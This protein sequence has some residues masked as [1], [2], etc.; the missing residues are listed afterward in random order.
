[1]NVL[2]VAPGETAT[3]EGLAYLAE[4]ADVVVGCNLTILLDNGALHD[5]LIVGDWQCLREYHDDHFDGARQRG[6]KFWT[7]SITVTEIYRWVEPLD[8]GMKGPGGLNPFGTPIWHLGSSGHAAIAFAWSILRGRD[9]YEPLRDQ[10]WLYGYTGTAEHFHGPHTGLCEVKGEPP[11]GDWQSN[12]RLI[13]KSALE[14]GLTI[15]DF[16]GDATGIYPKG[17]WLCLP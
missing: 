16:T 2:C 10:I 9:G 14:Y 4:K 8:L 5:H 17:D 13:A 7:P 12:H 15:L 11:V 6:V 3:P 1:M